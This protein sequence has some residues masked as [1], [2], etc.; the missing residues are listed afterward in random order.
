MIA[1]MGL[2]KLGEAARVRTDNEKS[3]S[4]TGSITEQVAPRSYNVSTSQGTYRC[5]TQHLMS[6]KSAE[7][8]NSMPLAGTERNAPTNSAIVNNSAT[9]NAI[10]S[11]HSQDSGYIIRSG[12]TVKPINKLT[13][14]MNCLGS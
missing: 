13:L 4:T 2:K 14:E 5:T 3:W 10:A 1:R 6:N 8:T 11:A 9:E 7:Q 12:S